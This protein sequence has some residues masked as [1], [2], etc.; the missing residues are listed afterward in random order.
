M[1]ECAECADELRGSLG[2]AHTR[3][4]LLGAGSREGMEEEG[5]ECRRRSG[6]EKEL[7]PQP[8]PRPRAGQPP[9]VFHALSV[10]LSTRDKGCLFATCPHQALITCDNLQ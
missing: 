7:P 8:V 3:T 9:K 10:G 5:K 2:R 6:E 1:E 4:T